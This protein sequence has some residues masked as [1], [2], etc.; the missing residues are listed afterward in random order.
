MTST[1]S[2][3]ETAR[4]STSGQILFTA[5][6]GA[7]ALGLALAFGL[8]GRD[9][10]SRLLEEVYQRG[11]EQTDQAKDHI[12]TAKQRGRRDVEQTRA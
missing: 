2:T 1:S 9:V 6:V 10:A 4:S 3:C 7:L 11:R 12:E 5:I 8:G